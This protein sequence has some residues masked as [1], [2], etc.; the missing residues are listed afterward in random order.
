MRNLSLKNKL[1]IWLL[2]PILGLL[3]LSITIS[4]DRYLIYTKLNML[5]KIVTV[6]IKTKD[7]IYSVQKERG[8][9]N[10]YIG[11]NGKT[12]KEKIKLQTKQT[13]KYKKELNEYLRNIDINY[14]GND[15]KDSIIKAIQHLNKIDFIREKTISLNIA[16]NEVNTYYTRLIDSFIKIVI[17]TSNFSND[18]ELSKKL[19]AHSNFIHAIEKTANERGLG[20]LAFSS[21]QFSYEM[22]TKIQVLIYEQNIYLNNFKRNL[23]EKSLKYFENTFKGNII[24]ESLRMRNS[25]VNTLEKKLIVSQINAL[26][27]YGGIIHNYHKYLLTQEV[28]YLIGI[29]NNYTQLISLLNSYKLTSTLTKEE[30]HNILIIESLLSKYNTFINNVRFTSTTIEKNMKDFIKLDG[31]KES[32]KALNDLTFKNFFNDDS[33]YWFSTMTKK[34]SLL[35]KVDTYLTKK[36]LNNTNTLAQNAKRHMLSYSFL[37]FIIILIILVLG[38]HISISIVDSLSELFEGIDRFFKFVNKKSSDIKLIEIKTNDEIAAISKV[39]N[40]KMLI[41]K[42]II[43]EDIIERA[44]QLEIEVFNKTNDLKEKNKEYKVL[45]DRFNTHVLASRTD[46]EGVITFVTDKFC[47]ESGYTREELLGKSH[48]IVRHPDVPSALYK[49]MWETIAMGK[50]FNAEF[51]NIRKDGSK[52]WIKIIIVPELDS[53]NNIIGYFSVKRKIDDKIKLRKLN[54]KL[55]KKI[56]KAIEQSRRKD[57]LLSYQTK[58]ATMG[59]MIGLIAHQWKQPLS[60]LSLKIQTMKYKKNINEEYKENFISENM[61][62]INFMTQ[63]IDGFRDFYRQDK[64]KE[65]FKINTC[66]E[67]TLTILKPQFTKSKIDIICEGEDFTINGLQSELQHVLVNLI[68]NAKDELIKNNIVN[69]EIKIITKIHENKGLVTVEDNAGGI[70]TEILPRIFEAYFTTKETGKGTGIGL[71]LSKTIIEDTMKGELL[72]SNTNKGA[73]FKIIMDLSEK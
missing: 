35:Q 2:F 62:I 68:S 63:T 14:Y 43:D 6:S 70:P 28:K 58:L 40:E 41:S 56:E 69:K 1:I 32:L 25:I 13:N 20:T 9:S 11:S 8:F 65:N 52:Y 3:F 22:K 37:C 50:K 71:Y 54:E 34:I 15:F 47:L 42:K 59:E 33:A 36:I 5:D 12:F 7:L 19:H 18:I 38:R 46:L 55:E 30:E 24:D 31:K 26:L 57:Q 48:N 53:Q 10:G 39:I 61:Q 64:L 72:V 17:N 4:Y 67:K 29:K 49:D 27:G 60:S 21:K 16:E 51:K 45:L 66:I 73:S 23:D 44:K